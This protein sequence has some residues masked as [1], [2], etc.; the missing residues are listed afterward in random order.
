MEFR[1]HTF[2][3][4]CWRGTIPRGKWQ[5]NI[6]NDLGLQVSNPRRSIERMSHVSKI[7]SFQKCTPSKYSGLSNFFRY[8]PSPGNCL[9]SS[10]QVRTCTSASPTFILYPQKYFKKCTPPKARDNWSFGTHSILRPFLRSPGRQNKKKI[11]KWLFHFW[12]GLPP[13]E[14]VETNL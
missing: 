1:C 11:S 6:N 8:A 10:D 3:V 13:I 9:K 12:V 14:S 2:Y 7:P 4:S 5:W